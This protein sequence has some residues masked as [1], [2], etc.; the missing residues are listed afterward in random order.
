[1]QLAVEFRNGSKEDKGSQLR[2]EDPVS[3]VSGINGAK[4]ESIWLYLLRA[5]PDDDD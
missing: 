5:Q 4:K 2:A 1:M 3:G